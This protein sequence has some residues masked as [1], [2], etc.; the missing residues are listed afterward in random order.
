MSNNFKPWEHATWHFLHCFVQKIKNDEFPNICDDM[1]EH[2]ISI[3]S[4]LPCPDCAYHS[5]E[6]MSKVNYKNIKSKNDLITIIYE[7]HNS[8]NKR[9]RKPNYPKTSLVKYDNFDF[10]IICRQ[11]IFHFHTKGNMKLLAHNLQRQQFINK[12]KLW[13]NNNINKFN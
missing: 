3:L 13:L 5:I 12:F 7:L 8:V 4:N 11:F 2:I 9:L 10:R 1:V 6:F